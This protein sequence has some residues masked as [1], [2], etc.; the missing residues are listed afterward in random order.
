MGEIN[1]DYMPT[2]E[3]YREQ[4][5][6]AIATTDEALME[7][8][9]NGKE[10]T[11]EEANEAVHKG[12]SDGSIVPVFSGAA[13]KLWGVDTLVEIT[14]DAFPNPIS[15][16]SERVIVDGKEEKKAIRTEGAPE[17][18]VFKTT[19][20]QFGRTTYFKVMAGELTSG[21]TLKNNRSG[22]AEKMAHF[23]LLSVK[24]P[25]RFRLFPAATSA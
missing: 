22:V 20:D 19:V 2:V 9:F 18:F 23:P 8:Y 21:V 4:L 13:T 1:T 15:K 3:K 11:K 16:G 24:R 10:I 14:A 12:V 5:F 17:L 25:P 7:K 6:E